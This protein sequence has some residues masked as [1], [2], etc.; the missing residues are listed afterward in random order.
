MLYEE[1]RQYFESEKG[2]E[3]K[4]K[5]EQLFDNNFHTLIDSLSV[6]VY[7]SK[8]KTIIDLWT[9]YPELLLDAFLQL[10]RSKDKCRASRSWLF[11]FPGCRFLS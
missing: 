10:G 8:K 4:H 5:L 6:E 7:D 2:L 3:Y 1:W 11:R 9:S